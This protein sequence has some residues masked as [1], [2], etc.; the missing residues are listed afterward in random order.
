MRSALHAVA[1][2]L[3]GLWAM[4]SAAAEWH[5]PLYLANDGYWHQRVRVDVQNAMPQDAAGLPAEVRISTAAGEANLVGA[6]AESVRVVDAA[7]VELLYRI[8]GPDGSTLTRGAIP[9]GS[10]LTIPAVCPAGGTSSVYVYFDN[11]AAWPVPDMLQGSVSVRNGGVEEGTGGTPAGWTHGYGDSQ[12]Q[13]SWTTEQAHGGSHALKLWVAPGAERQWISTRQQGL[14][15]R[16]G[17][18]YLLRGW[19]KAQEVSADGW[20]GWYIHVGNASNPMILI[21]DAQGGGGTFDWKEVTSEFTAPPDADRADIGTVLWG[22]GTAWFDDVSLECSDPPLVSATAAPVEMIAA[23]ESGAGAA[24]YDDDPSD[25]LHWDY[26]V[27]VVVVNLS[28]TA[29]SGLAQVNVARYAGRVSLGARAESIRL[30]DGTTLVP[31]YLVGNSVLFSASLPARTVHTYYLYL[32]TDARIPAAGAAGY[33]GLLESGANIV[34]N[35]SFEQGDPMPSGWDPGSPPAGVTIGLDSPGKFGERAAK[36]VV[37]ASVPVDSW[38][39]WHQNTAVQPGKSYFLGAWVKTQDVTDG[40]VQI[41]AHYRT[42][43]GELCASAQY[44]A[45]GAPLGGT[46]DW[47]LMTGTFTMPPDCA[48]FQL[49]LTVNAH[50]TIWHDGVVLAEVRPGALGALEVRRPESGVQA[51]PVNAVV[52]VFRDDPALEAG[53]A[54]VTRISAARGESEPLQLAVRSSSALAGLHVEVTPPR[55]DRGEQLTD[56]EVAVVGYV[57]VDFPTGYYQDNGPAWQRK[58]PKGEGQSDGW[59]GW[60]PDP[61]LPQNTFDLAANST[62][63]VWL[64]VRVPKD[65]RAGDY[66]GSA[67]VVGSADT[68]AEVPFTVH[69]WDFT[70]PD[71]R[72][73]PAIYDIRLNPW[74]VPPGA[75]EKQVRDQVEACM[76]D[77]RLC[78]DSISP[79]P[80]MSYEGGVVHADF[81]AYD[82]AA[83]RYFS[84][85]KMP[86]TYTPG[87]FYLFGWG[88]PPGEKFGEAPYEGTW[89][90]AD[91]DPSQ[92]RP[93]FKQAYQACLRAYWEHMKAKGWADKVV[94]YLSDEP[95]DSQPRIIAQ[96]KALCDMVHEVDPAI[97]IYVSTWHYQPAWDGSIDIWGIGH[98]GVVSPETMQQIRAKGDRMVFTTD[99]QMCIDTPYLAVERLLPHYAFSYGVEGYEFWGFTWLVNYNPYQFGWFPYIPQSD[100]PGVNYWV[101]YPNGDGFLAYPGAPIGHDG[102]VNSI[103]ME[104]AREGAEDYEY[105]WLLRDHIAKAQAAGMDTAAAEAALAG[106]AR[107]VS[108]PN[109]GGR[110]S[111]QILPDPDA[112]FVVREEVASAIEALFRFRDVGADYWAFREIQACCRAGVVKG[113]PDGRYQ[114]E[115]EVSRDQMAVFVARALAGGDALVPTGPAVPSFGDVPADH[116]AFRYIEYAHAQDV[117]LAY[118]DGSY[119]PTVV[120]TRDQMAVY[121]SR[122]LAG[123][124]EAVHVPTGVMTPSFT[125]VEESHWAYRHIEYCRDAGVVQGYPDGSYRP[126]VA[127]T[128]DQMAAYVARGFR[129]P[130]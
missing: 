26:R 58:F 41:N 69:V 14:V 89:P 99:G 9:A 23:T 118:E 70:L 30:T 98:Y 130:L 129:L 61:L 16:P 104:Q 123:G 86:R 7:G 65:A 102:P 19:V 106:A 121:I 52:K 124:D 66:A 84:E 40:T 81:T 120:V 55:N 33:E 85:L 10:T 31:H 2:A 67:R 63:P 72:H 27:P 43:S 22:S 62:Q 32:S 91:A 29:A 48:N 18:H 96:M 100:Q 35:P 37:G 13:A 126:E 45:A 54:M 46:N 47:T 42:A 76:S 51:W 28:E 95:F 71:E 111:T 17:A 75:S 125:D 53:I 38:P 80:V 79:D 109:A 6:A 122:A 117:V 1:V 82:A 127:V 97:P 64:T 101:R 108:I 105:L 3:L 107:L 8:S 78:P 44:A 21:A 87:V 74:W 68:L 114:P 103:R 92:L 15:I 83:E 60:W 77:H 112:V 12:H 11:P 116:W 115:L 56:T 113:Y 20:A 36:L 49:H 73:T 119:R 4:S 24:W 39:G 57:P 88:M 34:A 93:A 5:H 50:G 90:Y 25:D 128:R 110:Y 59:A 94:L